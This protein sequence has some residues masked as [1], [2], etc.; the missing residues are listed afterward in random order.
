MKI[1]VTYA[2]LLIVCCA[3]FQLPL[4]GQAITGPNV[5]CPNVPVHFAF[6]GTNCSATWLPVTGPDN[7]TIAAQSG[8]S[9]DYIFPAQKVAAV[10]RLSVGYACGSTGGTIGLEVTVNTVGYITSTNID[11]PCTSK[12]NQTFIFGMQGIQG[13]PVWSNNAGWPIASGPTTTQG[14]QTE[15]TYNINNTSIGTVSVVVPNNLCPGSQPNEETFRVTRSLSALSAPVFT[16]S[17]KN[18]CASSSAVFTVTPVDN[19]TNY[20]WT[21]SNPGVLING[22]PSPATISAANGG[23]SV[24]LSSGSTTSTGGTMTVTAQTGCGQTP[25]TSS[26]LTIG[27]AV[28]TIG[29]PSNVNARAVTYVALPELPGGKYTWYPGGATILTGAGTNSVFLQF[30]TDQGVFTTQVA[31]SITGSPATCGTTVNATK[32][33]TVNGRML[34]EVSPNPASNVINVSSASAINEM[35]ARTSIIQKQTEISEIMIVDKLNNIKKIVKYPA[36]T[37]NVHIDVSNL[38]ADMYILRIRNADTWS[39]RQIIVGA[40]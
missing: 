10:Y 38:P 40:H 29:G 6:S 11:V 36:G 32:A 27:P 20:I 19:A 37:R 28:V 16:T 34:F 18:I 12:G 8:N 13:T 23:N 30:P 4:L 17:T 15:I 33:V 2:C 3:L 31:V 22:Q 26:N 21:A 24:T 7:V 25:V 14:A 5:V 9:I 39:S 1:V 35:T